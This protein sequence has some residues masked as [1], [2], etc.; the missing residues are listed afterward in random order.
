MADSGR[1]FPG[2]G[3]K[4]WVVMKEN[5]FCPAFL[6]YGRVYCQ[7]SDKENNVGLAAST[8]EGERPVKN[9]FSGAPSTA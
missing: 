2:F 9:P 7:G 3:D 8:D 6:V 1:I 5:C 4:K